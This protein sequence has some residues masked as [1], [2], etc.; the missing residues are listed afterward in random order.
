[1]SSITRQ[2]EVRQDQDATIVSLHSKT[3]K[4]SP[5]W[6]NPRKR[7]HHNDLTPLF[8][9]IDDDD[10]LRA[11]GNGKA[12]HAPKRNRGR[13]WPLKD[14]DESAESGI[15][16]QKKETEGGDEKRSST[17]STRESKFQEG[18]MNDKV[19]RR[20]P[21]QYIKD[22]EA[23]ENY[24]KSEATDHD[25]T[26]CVTYDAGI[27][28]TRPSGV[29]RFGKVIASTF[30]PVNIWSGINGMWKE[31]EK[32]IKPSPAENVLQERQAKAIEAYAELKR[33]GYK[34]TQTGSIHREIQAIPDIK[35]EDAENAVRN[36]F[37]DS[38]IVVDE[39]RTSSE[40][41]RSTDTMDL[42][43]SLK[44]PPLIAANIRSTSPFSNA[45]SGRKSSLH[46]RKPSFQNLRRVT[47][48]IHLPSAK[49]PTEAPF[50]TSVEGEDAPPPALTGPEL[51]RQPSKKEI[52][53]QT[54]LTKKVSDL[55]NKL[56]VARQELELSMST[57]PPV[58]DLPTYLG[59]KTFVPGGL[60]SLPSER[61]MTPQQIADSG[62]PALAESGQTAN[63]G[64]TFKERLVE[65]P[66][67]PYELKTLATKDSTKPRSAARRRGAPDVNDE[68]KRKASTEIDQS[69]ESEAPKGLNPSVTS[70]R[71]MK[72]QDFMKT[73][74]HS[75]AGVKKR[76][77]PKI[78]A[79]TPQNSPSI[80]SEIVPPVPAKVPTFDPLMVDQGKIIS[81]R[82]TAS[83]ALFGALAEDLTNLHKEF[84]K[85]TE[86]ELVEYL[87]TLGWQPR[88]I[89][90][91]DYTSV[92]HD[93][94]PA[95]PF[96][97]RPLG[98]PMRT[99]SKNSKRGISPPPS[100]LSS[101]KKLRFE[102]YAR[103]S[104]SKADDPLKS[105]ALRRVSGKSIETA[106]YRKD[107]PLPD[108][109]K[110]EFDWDEDV[111]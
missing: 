97:G 60:S 49:K 52:S 66:Q 101:A 17:N 6:T 34:G 13:Q 74:S 57:A 102:P 68:N 31:K 96:L 33:S 45:S 27:E 14:S 69:V 62:G 53:R 7:P 85:A 87:Q 77:L 28:S 110:E 21:S 111:F 58:P 70:G 94:R 39:H 29:F 67:L 108:I 4:Q 88:A 2:E 24:V 78:P 48:Q 20:P 22:E 89:K 84:P 1:M 55:E 83:K 38:G 76:H 50:S 9:P 65:E 12:L 16:P 15:G 54:K 47:S 44:V 25:G 18:S 92:A 93:S 56:Q 46:F 64:R 10:A 36:N 98:S 105:R 72:P 73:S 99:R 91:T 81:M 86:N 41:K 37:R 32:N 82:S 51:R 11:E 26:A 100:S 95:S 19:S 79:K 61:N 109:Q 80:N 3:I 8:E 23:L 63:R 75:P 107:K 40:H 104:P 30:N 106:K 103:D 35:Y 43:E 5:S 59:R 71:H 90:T 42:N